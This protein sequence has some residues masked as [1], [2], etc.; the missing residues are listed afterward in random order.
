MIKIIEH[1]DEWKL[2]LED[3]KNYDFYHTYD[4]HLFSR[5][6][7]EKPILILYQENYVCIALPLLIRN[8]F[9]TQY[10]DATSVYGYAGPVS[11]N[12]DK[13]FDNTNFITALSTF[14]SEQKIITL[15]SR[16]NP[17]IK[18]QETVL[19]G[20]G[21]KPFS[22]EVVSID[23]TEP[24]DIQRSKYSRRTKTHV[25]KSRRFCTVRQ[26]ANKE[27]I[28]EYIDIYYENMD[29]VNATKS[30]YFDFEYFSKLMESQDFKSEVL[31][32]EHN[33]TKKII[34]GAMFIKTNDIVQYHLSGAKN[35]YL[36]LTPAKLLIDEMRVK[37]SEEKYTVLN[38]GGGLG[39]QNDSLFSFKS[40]FSKNFK[41]F[42]VWKY[43][44]NF[45]VYNDLIKDKKAQEIDTNFFP[46]YRL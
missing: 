5:Q 30:Y 1:K 27:E 22:G 21:E 25:N 46:L 42:K 13:N 39:G 19:E 44:L 34:A 32:I 11:K 29:R 38:L 17:F 10:Y 23:L 16:L 35:D 20:L 45:E 28:K 37:A 18:H 43:I 15:F 4:Y 41:P 8:V 7:G 36:D 6:K 33:E 2:V 31:V 9:D 24:I 3:I 40:S 14:L 12:I 26:A